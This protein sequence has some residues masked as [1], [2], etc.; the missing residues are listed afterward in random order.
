MRNL[1]L[2]YLQFVIIFLFT[3][4]ANNKKAIDD[5]IEFTRQSQIL[6]KN[7]NY[8]EALI[9]VNK[10]IELDNKNYAAYNNLGYIKLELNYP[11]QEVY[12][13]F[14][15]SYDLNENYLVALASLTNFQC[16]TKNYNEAVRF[17]K[18]YLEKVDKIPETA[19]ERVQVLGIIG[20]SYNYLNSY[21]T[22]IIYL[23]KAL[24]L[25][26]TRAGSYKERGV[27]FRNIGEKHK[28]LND[29]NK[30]IEIDSLYSQ[31]YNSRAICYDNLNMSDKALADYNKAISLEPNSSVYFLNRAILRLNLGYKAEACSD[32]YKSDSLGNNE[33]KNYFKYC[34]EK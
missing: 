1:T 29:F 18:E 21:D 26:S 14:K 15:K 10:A 27:A 5:S 34:M 13:A 7:K 32:I 6:I 11:E 25:D 8:Q 17:G 16:Y 33:A 12:E 9:A 4:C 22:A 20:E 24:Q 19:N 23:T 2:R 31:A 28:A 30:A 3:S